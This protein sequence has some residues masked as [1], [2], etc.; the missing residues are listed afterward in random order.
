MRIPQILTVS[1]EAN[2]KMIFC[3]ICL[4]LILFFSLIPNGIDGSS[5]SERNN[6]EPEQ[7]PKSVPRREVVPKP[8]YRPTAGSA[9]APPLNVH[10]HAYA[11]NKL[12]VLLS[13]HSG[14]F[15]GGLEVV[16]LFEL[17]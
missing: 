10:F 9:S 13:L 3:V 7:K 5:G 12:L 4:F 17:T 8:S 16:Y 1:I 11:L 2:S 14:I 6:S 15:C